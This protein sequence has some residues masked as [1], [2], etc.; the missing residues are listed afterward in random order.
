[1]MIQLNP[2]DLCQEVLDEQRQESNVFLTRVT[3][4]SESQPEV[5]AVLTLEDSS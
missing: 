2:E 3:T 5:Q 1:M 4:G